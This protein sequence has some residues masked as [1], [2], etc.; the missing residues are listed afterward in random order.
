VPMS[1]L[2]LAVALEGA[3]SHPAAWRAGDARPGE[4][5]EP[6][7]WVDLVREA[8][9][10]VLDFVTI[11]DSLALQSE[12]RGVPDDR[13]DQVRGRLDAVLVAARVAPA[14]SHIGLVPVATTTHTEPFHVSKAIATLDYVSTGRAG[15]QIRVSG[16]QL[17]AAQFG[18]R[19]MPDGEMRADNLSDPAV[20]Q[21]I[22]E[23]F[24]EAA[25]FVEVLRRL[26]DSWD[27]DAEIRDVAS[28]RFIDRD[29]LHYIDFEGRWFSVRGPSITPRPPQGQPL[30]TALAHGTIPYRLAARQ[31]DAVFV[32]PRDEGDVEGIVAEVR[33]EEAAVD[34]ELDP[35]RIFAD[36]VV[37]LDDE[38]GAAE[39]RRIHLDE[40]NGNAFRSDALIFA[41]TPTAL[42][43]LLHSWETEGLAGF[44]LRPGSLPHD[45]EGIT[46]GLIPLL[47]RQ[48][49]APLR[50]E[51]TTLRSRLG[52]DRPAN[53]YAQLSP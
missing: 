28:G 53:R 38:A 3:G 42:A 34:R 23:R 12:R 41:G 31:A 45:L 21:L 44:R 24:D 2:R 1:S 25:D 8:E 43:E 30:V 40:L 14:T 50:Y 39:E 15:V 49:A 7:Y 22:A 33:A 37:F 32:T 29:R 9:R 48:G 11:D 16:T 4:L 19:V 35:L 26:W 20:L 51:E 17:E 10:G 36:L 6:G 46:R 18:R 27:D 52:L 13:V 5:F 47:Q